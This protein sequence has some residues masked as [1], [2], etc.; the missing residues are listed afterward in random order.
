DAAP[1]PPVIAS[2]LAEATPAAWR[3]RGR[4]M[5]AA[6]APAAAYD[7]F[8]AAV[9]LDPGDADALR[10]LVDTAASADRWATT[11]AMLERL[12]DAHPGR[13]AVWVALSRLHA[14]A[15][16]LDR[17]LDAAMAACAVSPVDPAALEQ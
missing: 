10:G 5:R 6:G 7:D 1:P 12:A 16:M 4:M 3:N 2:A 15:G 17:A 8:A 13:A 9:R 11:A 14:A